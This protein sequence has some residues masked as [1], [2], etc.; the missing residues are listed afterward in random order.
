MPHARLRC[1]LR[2]GGPAMRRIGVSAACRGARSRCTVRPTPKRAVAAGYGLTP[3][4]PDL[5]SFALRL[6]PRALATCFIQEITDASNHSRRC[7]ARRGSEHCARRLRRQGPRCHQGPRHA[8]VRRQHR[9]GRLLRGRQPGQ[10]DRPGR[11]LLPRAGRRHPGRR[12]QGALLA[13][14]G[15][16]ALHRAAVG[17]GRRAVAQHHLD[18]D[19]RRLAGHA[20]R[21]RHL[22][23][24][25]GLHGAEEPERE[26]RQGAEGRHRVRAVRHHHRAEPDRLLARQQPAPQA[27]GVREAGGRRPAPTSPAA[28]RS[29]PPTPRAWPRS[30]ARKRRSPT[31]T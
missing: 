10:V 28:A 25:P 12:Q 2:R 1:T 23:R 8:G 16:A 18:A 7:R 27:G 24:R 17:R 29:S 22:L 3:Q 30:A 5:A 31:T 21:R 19:A 20:L 14:D 4:G 15:A 9:P 13:A 6:C 26:E 11:R